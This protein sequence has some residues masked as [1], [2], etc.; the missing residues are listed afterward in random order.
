[1]TNESFYDVC[2]A[3]CGLKAPIPIHYNCMGGGGGPISPVLLKTV[4]N[5]FFFFMN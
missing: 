1:M 4:V 2:G 5:N 3:S